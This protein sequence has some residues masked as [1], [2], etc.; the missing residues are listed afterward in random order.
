MRN[1]PINFNLADDSLWLFFFPFYLVYNILIFENKP[2]NFEKGWL[3]TS[4][5]Q[6]RQREFCNEIAF[7]AEIQLMVRCF[8]NQ[9]SN[10]ELGHI[11][12]FNLPTT[13]TYVKL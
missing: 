6:S 10:L 3:N 7:L 9:I 2:G 4:V 1:H 12:F 11:K 8:F 13:D 5:A